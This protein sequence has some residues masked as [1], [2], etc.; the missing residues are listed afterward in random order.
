MA[1]TI[2]PAAELAKLRAKK[3]GPERCKEIAMKASHATR[4]YKRAQRRAKNNPT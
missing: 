2:N 1:A 4:H 3:L